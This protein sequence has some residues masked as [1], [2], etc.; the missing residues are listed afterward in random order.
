MIALQ[1]KIIVAVD[2]FSSCGK[3]SYSK[4]IA[5]ELQYVYLDSGAMYRAVALYA[6][7]KGWVHADT[8]L[9]EVIVL[10]LQDIEI[11]FRLMDGENTTFLNGENIENEIRGVGV[12]SVV[13]K[14]S[15]IPEVRSYLVALQQKMGK[16]KGI[17][18][19]GRDIGTVVFPEAELKIYMQA[20]AAVRAKRRYDELQA[21]GMPASLE[22]ITQNINDRDHLDIN[23]SVSPLVKADDAL[24]LDNSYMTFEEQMGWFRNVLKVKGLLVN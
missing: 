23:R 6:L 24:V 13:S 18:M 4:L 8:V 17:V 3:S 20:D 9:A 1:K 15:K 5:K 7:R 21:K 16:V 12:S 10:H 11:S 2:G 22:E 14:V 19:D